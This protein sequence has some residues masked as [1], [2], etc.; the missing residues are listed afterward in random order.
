[1]WSGKELRATEIMENF[2][3]VGT[4]GD[5]MDALAVIKTAA[6]TLEY[7]TI[8]NTVLTRQVL[9]IEALFTLIDNVLLPGMGAFRPGGRPYQQ[10]SIGPLWRSWM[11]D[12]AIMAKARGEKFM[13]DFWDDVEKTFE[14]VVDDPTAGFPPQFAT[15][16]HAVKELVAVA[17]GSWTPGF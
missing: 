17:D 6:W 10:L 13:T 15:T 16:Y 4:Q 1:M 11:H 7:H 9:R 12:K 5:A 3:A 8:A 14:D 2:I